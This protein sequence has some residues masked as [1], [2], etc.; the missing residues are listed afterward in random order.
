MHTYD[1][2]NDKKASTIVEWRFRP[3]FTPPEKP[4]GRHLNHIK[5]IIVNP[6]YCISLPFK[7]DYPPEHRQRHIIRRQAQIRIIVGIPSNGHRFRWYPM[8]SDGFI[9]DGRYPWTEK[10][11]MLMPFYH[12]IELRALHQYDKYLPKQIGLNYII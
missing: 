12:Y 2:I 7:N 6:F 4:R 5:I 1:M 11:K 8:I 9:S 3:T 10:Y